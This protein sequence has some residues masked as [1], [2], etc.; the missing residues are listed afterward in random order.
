MFTLD[1]GV[2]SG[3]S[4]LRVGVECEILRF[5]SPRPD[6]G[7]GLLCTWYPEARP[8]RMYGQGDCESHIP[9]GGEYDTA[10]VTV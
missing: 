10:V 1:P 3:K 4:H 8:G 2:F 5:Y 9:R 7:F 6:L